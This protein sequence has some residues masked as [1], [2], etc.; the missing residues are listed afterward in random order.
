MDH[1]SAMLDGNLDN[2]VASEIGTNRG[3]LASLANDICLVGLWRVESVTGS[4]NPKA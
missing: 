3:V 2:L 4:T 1:L